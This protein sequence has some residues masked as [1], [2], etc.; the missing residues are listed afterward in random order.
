M[1]QVPD[2]I[3]AL[4][5][6]CVSAGVEAR[7]AHARVL[8]L[9]AQHPPAAAMAEAAIER[10]ARVHQKKIRKLEADRRAIERRLKMEEGRWQR[11]RARLE[12]DN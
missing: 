7:R 11:Q 1:D 2:H 12:T 5:E 6:R 8:A 3:E 9:E 4:I 10:A